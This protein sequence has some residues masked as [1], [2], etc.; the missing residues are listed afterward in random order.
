MGA[1][2]TTGWLLVVGVVVVVPPPTGG[3][4]CGRRM[5]IFVSLTEYQSSSAM[6]PVSPELGFHDQ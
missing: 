1:A 3:T 2:G 5:F 4:R 6:P